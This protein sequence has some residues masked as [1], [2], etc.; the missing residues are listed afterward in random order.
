MVFNMFIQNILCSR[1]RTVQFAS[2]GGEWGQ[3]EDH[4]ALPWSSLGTVLPSSAVAHPSRGCLAVWAW[5]YL[6]LWWQSVTT[7][8]PHSFVFNIELRLYSLI[9]I[10]WI[11]YV[12][13]SCWLFSHHQDLVDGGT[14]VMAMRGITDWLIDLEY[15]E[16][17]RLLGN[18]KYCILS[19]IRYHHNNLSSR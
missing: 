12:W 19:L 11:F 3:T 13:N 6:P 7:R 8:W 4:S 17:S 10:N 15:R 16:L 14:P 2:W 1:F 9:L 18:N 5:Q